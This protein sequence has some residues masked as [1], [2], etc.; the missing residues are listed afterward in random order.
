MPEI[1]AVA[2]PSDRAWLVLL[3]VGLPLLLLAL[4]GQDTNWDLRNYHLYNPHAWLQQ[5]DGLD[6]APAQLQSWHNPL[7][8][9]PL[10]LMTQA[11]WHGAWIGLWL[12]LPT[13][14]AIHCLLRLQRQLT[15]GPVPRSASLALTVIALLGAGATTAL[16]SSFNDAFVA[17][18]MLAA[19]CCVVGPTPVRPRAWLIAGVIAGA[20]MGLKLTA[21]LY[22]LGLAGAAAVGG[23]MRGAPQ[24]LLLL[25][26]GGLLGFALTYGYWAW[27]LFVL[28][29]NPV[30]PY[31][32]QV[33]QSPDALPVA[34]EDRRYRPKTVMDAFWVPLRLLQESMRYSEAPLR[35]P[36]MLLGVLAWPALALLRPRLAAMTN[37]LRIVLAF[38]FVSFGLWLVQYGIYRYLLPL[39]MLSGLAVVLLLARLPRRWRGAAQLAAVIVIV[40]STVQPHWGRARFAPALTTMTRLPANSLVVISSWDPLAHGVLRLEGRVPVLSMHNNFMWPDR[41]TRLQEQVW[42]RLATHE[43]PLWLLRE[44]GDRVDDQESQLAAYGLQRAGACRD[45]PTDYETLSLCPLVR[46][47]VPATCP[48]STAGSGR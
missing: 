10:Y 30:F 16:G 21:A 36:R 43:G 39:E 11:R 17:G 6:I 15:D 37:D 20:V 47:P 25:A 19:L 8:D 23:P 3:S 26:L 28:H 2:T 38:F 32:N 40:A 42:T 45:L 9:V 13:L 46:H 48:P 14:L 29:G 1:R 34:I 33:F 7:L 35:D 31:F 41:C 12:T 5:R 44:G 24:R 4:L 22:C 18:G 27:H